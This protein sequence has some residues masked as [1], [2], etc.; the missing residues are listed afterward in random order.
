MG[1]SKV[2]SEPV[3][4]K[5]A[6]GDVPPL[7]LKNEESGGPE[8]AFGFLKMWKLRLPL[9]ID[10]GLASIPRARIAVAPKRIR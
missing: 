2:Q 9:F 1:K 6:Q 5:L 10:H 7:L 8:F 4:K 3:D